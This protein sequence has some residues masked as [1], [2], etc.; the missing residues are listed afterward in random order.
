MSNKIINDEA[1]LFDALLGKYDFPQDADFYL[2]VYKKSRRLPKYWVPEHNKF[3]LDIIDMHE[4]D[5]YLKLKC[6]NNT[7][8]VV[9]KEKSLF[10]D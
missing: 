5:L 2:Y 1:N 8:E 6:K 7:F 10:K 3:M 4:D 9:E